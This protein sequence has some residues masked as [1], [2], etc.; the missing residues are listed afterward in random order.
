[1]QPSR[2]DSAAAPAGR[3]PPGVALGWFVDFVA[4]RLFRPVRVDAGAAEHVRMLGEKSALVYVVRYRSLFDFL[5]VLTALRNAGMPLPVF[6]PNL[7]TFWLHPLRSFVRGVGRWLRARR[8]A[9]RARVRSEHRERFRRL[10]EQRQPVLVFMRS[11]AAGVGGMRRSPEALDRARAGADYL[12][13]IVIGQWTRPGNVAFVPLAIV[14]G[15]GY[16]RRESRL[17]ALVY[18]VQQTPGELRRLGSFLWNRGDTTIVVG[19]DVALRGLVERHRAEGAERIVRRLSRALQIF[20]YREERMVQGPTLLNPAQVRAVVLSD[21]SLL[22]YVERWAW[23]KRKPVAKVWRRARRILDGMAANYQG[24]YITFLEAVLNRLWRRMFGRLECIGLERVAA[25]LRQHPIVLVPCHRSHFDYLILSYIFHRNH[26]SPPHIAAG[27]NLSFWP[28]GPIFRGAGAFFIRRSFGDDELYKLVFR[29]YLTFLIREGY[30]QEFF[31]EGT[32]SRS[33]KLM[34]PKLGMLAALVGAFLRG[35]RRDLYFVPVSIQYSRVVEEQAYQRELEGGAKEKESLGALVRARSLA[36]QQYG[37]VQVTFAEPISL[38]AALGDL[39]E[40]L[41]DDSPGGRPVELPRQAEERKRIFVEDLAFRIQRAIND[42]ST[43]TDTAIAAT[44][45]LGGDAAAM[46]FRD[47]LARARTLTSLLP[48]C[49][50]P[51]ETPQDFAATRRFLESAGLVRRL[52]GAPD[53]IHVPPER[54]VSLDFYRNNSLHWFLVPSLLSAELLAGGSGPD[55]VEAAVDFWLDLY[56]IEF[57]AP[58][59]ADRAALVARVLGAYRDAGALGADGVVVRTHPLLAV[60]AGV[61]DACHE[62]YWLV[63]RVLARL[64]SQGASEKTLLER[65]DSSYAAGFL[66]GEVR[67]PEGQSVI[68]LRNALQRF[69]DAGCIAEARR[70]ARRLGRGRERWLVPGENAAWLAEVERRLAAI[71][72]RGGAER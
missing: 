34:P 14:R 8:G 63:A 71:L 1:M 66:L 19:R 31:I 44:V 10:V 68:T 4:R 61:L 7:P 41:R 38:A 27:D 43:V 72:A 46:R 65:I 24:L 54:R 23:A 57:P 36:R 29:S 21:P 55:G 47:F 33:G 69:V 53:V 28:L 50:A 45:L 20:L 26:L 17:A 30:T 64:E 16:R 39:R 48:V 42:A 70:P 40:E 13:E 59:G 2:P 67:K 60:T 25:T 5:L 51:G 32:R 37:D 56:R 22:R 3:R 15:R 35:V 18:T 12:R 49:G 6:A 9:E 62:P 58:A 11:R 52:A